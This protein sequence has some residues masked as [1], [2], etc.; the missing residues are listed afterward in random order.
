MELEALKR[1][2][3]N[4]CAYQERSQQQVRQKLYEYGLGT[5]QVEEIIS[6]LIVAGFINEER[7][8][9]I[10]V[11][12]K[13]RLKK[14][15]RIKI[16]NGLNQHKISDYCIKK[17]LAEIDDNDYHETLQLLLSKKK[18]TLANLNTTEQNNK[19]IRYATSKGFEYQLVVET[20]KQI[21]Q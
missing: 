5:E 7:F 11:S 12:G 13:F 8:A 2:I 16:V 18:D 14:W 21:D 3:E 1:K 15:G 10:Y 6:E 20:L 17:G 4:Y 19:L 9:K